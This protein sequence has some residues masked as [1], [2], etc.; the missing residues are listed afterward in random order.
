[1]D[2]YFS[3]VVTTILLTLKQILPYP[4]GSLNLSKWTGIFLTTLSTLR[5]S[6]LLEDYKFTAACFRAHLTN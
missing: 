3:F 2:I 1:M 4:R 6:Y 5:I